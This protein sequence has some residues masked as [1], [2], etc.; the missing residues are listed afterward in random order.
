[1]KDFFDLELMNNQEQKLPCVL[2]LDTSTSMLGQPIEELKNGLNSFV[3]G[4]KDDNYACIQAQIMVIK[5]GD[6]A[7]IICDWTD[8]KS[9]EIPSVSADG[10]NNLSYAVHLASKEIENRKKEFRSNGVSYLKPWVFIMSYGTPNDNWQTAASNFKQLE[11]EGKFSVFTIAVGDADQN[12]LS[13]FSIREPQKLNDIDFTKLF[14]WIS[15]SVQIK[16]GP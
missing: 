5:C 12:I 4:V 1:M 16:K 10:I 11:R 13:K 2:I 6:D 15:E 7:E 8:A 9:F 14:T 3:Q